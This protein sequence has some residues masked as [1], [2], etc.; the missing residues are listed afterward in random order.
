VL[1]GTKAR[2][3]KEVQRPCWLCGL[4]VELGDK[5]IKQ[6]APD[7]NQE[8]LET[9]YTHT[10]CY[11]SISWETWDLVEELSKNDPGSL[12]LI[13]LLKRGHALGT[14]WVEWYEKR[15]KLKVESV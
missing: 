6:Y 4:P 5:Y 10:I 15:V 11:S 1:K 12:P 7:N 2:F 8:V 9:V 13:V 3:I 14:G